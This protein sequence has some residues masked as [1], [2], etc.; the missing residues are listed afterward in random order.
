MAS[1]RIPPMV[2]LLL[3]LSLSSTLLP[4]VHTKTIDLTN[5]EFEDRVPPNNTVVVSAAPSGNLAVPEFGTLRVVSNV[6][7]ETNATN[8]TVLGLVVGLV[9]TLKDTNSLYLTF[10]FVYE[11]Q[12][13]SGTIGVQGKLDNGSGELVVTGGSGDFRLAQ[14]WCSTTLLSSSDQAAVFKN[15]LHLEFDDVGVVE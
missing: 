10:N 12:D 8:S 7:R 3:T 13:Y 2:A 11:T 15:E 1:F 4:I 5:F 9:N 14:G 6:L